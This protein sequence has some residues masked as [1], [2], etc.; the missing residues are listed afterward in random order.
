MADG[1]VQV[2][3]VDFLV[4]DEVVDIVHVLASLRSVELTVAVRKH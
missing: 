4:C 3:R 1:F 2:R